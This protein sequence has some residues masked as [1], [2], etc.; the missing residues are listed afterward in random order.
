VIEFALDGTERKFSFAST[1][2]AGSYQFKQVN[3][4]SRESGEPLD[5]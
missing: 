5:G 2:L 3:P 1:R 4:S